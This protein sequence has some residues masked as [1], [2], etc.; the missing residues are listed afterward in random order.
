M[1]VMLKKSLLTTANQVPVH[2]VVV[3][4]FSSPLRRAAMAILRA[5]LETT[6]RWWHL[7]VNPILQ[8]RYPIMVKCLDIGKNIGKT[9]YRSIFTKMLIF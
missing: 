1:A 9:I 6:T 5:I 3:V 7:L 8:D 4:V 2:V